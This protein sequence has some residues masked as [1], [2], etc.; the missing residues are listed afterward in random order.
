MLIKEILPPPSE[1]FVSANKTIF[2]Q[3]KTGS[4]ITTLTAQQTE[5]S[6]LSK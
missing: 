5:A 6:I 1:I 2:N 3:H 4:T